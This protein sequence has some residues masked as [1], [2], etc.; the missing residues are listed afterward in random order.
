MTPRQDVPPPIGV[1]D[2]DEVV[3]DVGDWD[4]N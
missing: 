4:M 1:D 2:E 3:G